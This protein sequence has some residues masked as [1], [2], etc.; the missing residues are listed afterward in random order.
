PATRPTPRPST[1]TS[2]PPA[3]PSAPSSSAPARTSSWP[4]RPAPCSPDGSV[5]AGV[6]DG[7]GGDLGDLGPEHVEGDLL[8][9]L[10]RHHALDAA[11]AL[12]DEPE[13]DV[14]AVDRGQQH[15]AA[16]DLDQ[17]TDLLDR[18]GE[19]V[20]VDHAGSFVLGSDESAVASRVA[21]WRRLRGRVRER[22]APAS[23]RMSCPVMQRARSL[24]RKTQRRASSSCSTMRCSAV[25]S[26]IAA[27][28]SSVNAA[29]TVSVSVVPGATATTRMPLGPSSTAIDVTRWLIAA[30][31]AA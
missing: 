8:E 18:G 6:V 28:C 3:P 11:R 9:E 10:A 17:G 24:V 21:S 19:R 1:P 2:P 31:A 23:A 14:A 22:N 4:A 15:V 20:G 13:V 29:R 27:T 16:V 7:D 25:D 12:D 30:F 26:T 5:L